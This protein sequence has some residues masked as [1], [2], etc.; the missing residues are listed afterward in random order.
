MFTIYQGTRRCHHG[1]HNFSGAHA[2][3]IKVY[4]ISRQLPTQRVVRADRAQGRLGVAM[5]QLPGLWPRDGH[6]DGG[7]EE[8]VPDVLPGRRQGV[9]CA[10][11]DQLL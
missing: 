6:G 2:N 3:L 9:R 1:V 4:T 5:R 10:S 8:A 7:T 11:Q